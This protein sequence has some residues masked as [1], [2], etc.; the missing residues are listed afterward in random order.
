MVDATVEQ[1]RSVPIFATASG[2]ELQAL[3]SRAQRVEFGSR[4]PILT[5]GQPGPGLYVL[6]EGSAEV[7]IDGI[8]HHQAGV[9]DIIGEISML[10]GGDATATVVTRSN[11][12]ALLLTHDDFALAVE[13]HGAIALRVIGILVERMRGDQARL[14]AYNRTLLDYIDQVKQI[15]D[16]AAAVEASVFQPV[17]LDAVTERADE[18]GQ[19][20]RVFSKMAAEVETRERRLRQE[21]QRLRISL[22]QRRADEQVAAITETDYFQELQRAADRLRSSIQGEG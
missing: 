7:I 21:V 20:A 16:A 2:D 17:M 15:T 14:A 5:Q 9:G 4:E 19:L 1:L 6:L 11:L 13:E 12:T 22:D 10:G 3:A 8:P 18:L